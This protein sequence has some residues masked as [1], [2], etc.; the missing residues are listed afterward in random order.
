MRLNKYF[1]TILFIS[2]SIIV[3]A[4]QD[5]TLSL[6]Q[7]LDIAIKNNLN[8]KQSGL[9]M[10]QDRIA[11]NQS[12]ENLLP[13]ITGAASRELSQ[14]RG[15]N[16]VTNT[17]V[18]QSLTSD[19]YSLNGSLVLFNGLAL[20]NSI[21]QTKLA[22]Q[23]GKMDFQAAKDL[24]TVSI[25]TN[26]L[27][28]LN[29][30]EILSQTKSQMAVSQQNV[31]RS[32]ILEQS[33]AN[34]IASDFTDFKGALAG[35]QVAVVN[36]QN[37]LNLARL[38]LYQL[39]NIPYNKSAE[40]QPL[41]AQDL[42]GDYGVNP[43]EVYGTALQ[44]LAVVKAA[45]LRRESAEKG[46]SVAKGQ[47][48]PTLALNGGISTNYSS[49]GQ[50]SVFIDST[51]VPTGGF[52]NT[53]TGK[54]SVFAD[55]A[56]Y[57]DQ[58]IKY[59]DQFKNNYGTALTL[60]LNIPIF[61]NHIKKNAVA[62]AKINL[63]NEQLIEANTKI[64]LKQNVEQAYY[65]MLSAYNTFKATNEQVNAYTESYRISKI[66]LDAGVITSVDFI[67]AQNNLDAAKLNLI[68]ARYDYFIYSKILDYY[69]GK[70]SL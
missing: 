41:N 68:S 32:A 25:I 39:M 7:C 16:P 47:L 55:Q 9:T 59:W 38:S 35:S 51:V 30:E 24:V 19:N 23:A 54:Q 63:E 42:V 28:V 58:N 67:I 50:K 52:I 8:V 22:Y 45:T 53:P 20:Q 40:L 44:Q 1:L 43:D 5:S 2:C 60:G 3:H 70:L 21:K 11:F 49:A 18:N 37:N 26:Y 46:V 36:A 31:D 17:Y 48:L 65:N 69:Q 33:G 10:E 6:Q 29:S 4:Q 66:R 56:N 13:S 57:S 34:K 62:L 12:K 61:T 64:Q 14:G 27:A 15:I